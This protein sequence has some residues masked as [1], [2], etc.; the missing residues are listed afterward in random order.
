MPRILPQNG[1]RLGQNQ[2][3]TATVAVDQFDFAGPPFQHVQGGD[4]L[5]QIQPQPCSRLAMGQ[6]AVGM[7]TRFRGK[8]RTIVGHFENQPPLILERFKPDAGMCMAAGIVHGIRERKHQ[9][10]LMNSVISWYERYLLDSKTENA[11]SQ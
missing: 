6:L 5:C 7:F 3:K 4:A 1:S 10:D 8:P 9:I 11:A 2:T